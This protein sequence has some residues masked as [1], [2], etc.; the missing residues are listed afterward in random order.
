MTDKEINEE[1]NAA[2][3]QYERDNPTRHAAL[4]GPTNQDGA[5]LT[6]TSADEEHNHNLD[7]EMMP[8]PQNFHTDAYMNEYPL[9]MW[10]PALD[11]AQN[12][13]TG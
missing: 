13:W 6:T 12:E 2:L 3:A 4:A 11:M 8:D 10:D 9:P 1:L 7:L 5:M